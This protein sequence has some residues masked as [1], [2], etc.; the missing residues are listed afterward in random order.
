MWQVSGRQQTEAA[1]GVAPRDVWC[2]LRRLDPDLFS[3]CEV[4]VHEARRIF[5]TLHS[6]TVHGGIALGEF[7]KWLSNIDVVLF[8]SAP[9]DAEDAARALRL[10]S[11]LVPRF[12][13][14]AR[15]MELVA[16][17][18]PWISPPTEDA[19]LGFRMQTQ[20]HDG[21]VTWKVLWRDPFREIERAGIVRRG[22]CLLGEH[23]SRFL[24]G[25]GPREALREHGRWLVERLLL[26]REGRDLFRK[27]GR[28][29]AEASMRRH[30]RWGADREA[31]GLVLDLCRVM[32]GLD[33][34]RMV[35]RARAGE[36]AARHIGGVAG[37]L[38]AAAARYRLRGE[39]E[40]RRRFLTS[41]RNFPRLVQVFVERC[42]PRLYERHV[43]IGRVRARR[44]EDHWKEF[45]EK[46]MQ[47]LPA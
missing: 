43:R 34:G 30:P 28:L 33:S 12:G 41:L 26:H 14:L 11:L 2:R 47:Q 5:P 29:H 36:W 22:L 3:L 13:D 19:M 42:F 37:A 38:A 44:M 7:S 35:P 32:E 10:W 1:L 16:L 8:C 15:R 39:P 4:L 21:R 45:A 31:T 20:W 6:L 25:I 27:V 23:P 17:P 46:V 18:L 40:D 9:V 24:E